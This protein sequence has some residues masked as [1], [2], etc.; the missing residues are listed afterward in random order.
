V[1]EGADI[2]TYSLLFLLAPLLLCVEFALQPPHLPFAILDLFAADGRVPD[3]SLYHIE[4][5]DG[6]ALLL[7]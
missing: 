4:G 2:T 5:V 3:V 6:E 7:L 1:N